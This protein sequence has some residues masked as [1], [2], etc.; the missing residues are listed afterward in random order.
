MPPASVKTGTISGTVE[1]GDSHTPL[2]G[3]TV[4]LAFQGSGTVN[5]TAVTA[6][7]GSYTLSDVPTGTYLRLS[8]KGH[9]YAASSHVTVHPDAT[10]M[11]DFGPRKDWAGPGTGAT[12]TSS[13]GKDYSDIG[14]GPDAAIDGSQAS[15]WSTN[16][17]PGTSTDGGAGFGAKQVTVDL[18]RVLDVT[19]FAVDPSSTC[20]DD[21]SSS[22]AGYTIETSADGTTWSA[23]TPGTFTPSDNG[24]LVQI[25]QT[26]PGVQYVRFTIT[27]NQTTPTPATYASTCAAGSPKSGCTYTDL[28]ELE[29]FGKPAP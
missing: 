6:A 15:G 12:V 21:I 26:D 11:V 20:G 24:T 19:G 29:V 27:S 28:S 17:G 9:G 8:V 4:T 22:V 7:D 14:C 23:P 10:T 25:D 5:P 18:G 1:D 3:L 16:A 2:Q 13:S